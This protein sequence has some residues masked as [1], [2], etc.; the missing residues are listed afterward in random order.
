MLEARSL[1]HVH[2]YLI[3]NPHLTSSVHKGRNIDKLKR[4]YLYY[5]M[6]LYYTTAGLCPVLR[7]NSSIVGYLK[8]PA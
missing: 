7:Q 3:S 4:R 6:P 2:V 5:S 1:F 8:R